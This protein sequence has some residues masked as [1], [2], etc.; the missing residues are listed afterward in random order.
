MG[1]EIVYSET[2]PGEFTPAPTRAQ[3]RALNREAKRQRERR[4]KAL[5]AVGFTILWASVIG[6]IAVADIIAFGG[7]LGPDSVFSKIV[8]A[9]GWA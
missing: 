6:F 2:K 3:K 8:K 9:F 1:R 7:G 4:E 5:N